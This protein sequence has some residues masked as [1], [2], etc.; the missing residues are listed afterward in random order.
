MFDIY[1]VGT[2]YVRTFSAFCQYYPL[3]Y[4]TLAEFIMKGR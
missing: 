4:Y 3:N 2:S 1:V